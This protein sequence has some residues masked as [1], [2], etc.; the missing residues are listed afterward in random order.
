MQTG[1]GK[2]NDSEICRQGG[3]QGRGSPALAKVKGTK[4]EAR[5]GAGAGAR[6][7]AR[8]R[9]RAEARGRGFDFY[10]PMLASGHRTSAIQ[11]PLT[12]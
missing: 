3:A 12:K 1:P 5:A 10:E 7:R 11:R 2:R 8:A 9:V 4:G 6:A